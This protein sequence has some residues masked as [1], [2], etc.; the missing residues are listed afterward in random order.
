MLCVRKNFTII[1][2]YSCTDFRNA[3][4]IYISCGSNSPFFG[5]G[6]QHNSSLKFTRKFLINRKKK[7]FVFFLF[8]EFLPFFKILILQCT[9]THISCYLQGTLIEFGGKLGLLTI[10]QDRTLTVG[11]KLPCILYNLLMCLCIHAQQLILQVSECSLDLPLYHE[12]F[13]AAPL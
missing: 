13:I 1:N 2:Q 8:S 7:T 9:W 4:M 12:Y 10:L 11:R 3:A 6:C 5:A